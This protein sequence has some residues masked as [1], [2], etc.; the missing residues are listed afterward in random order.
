[1]T[2][3]PGIR[4]DAKDA[5]KTLD[6][7]S[8]QVA[9]QTMSQLRTLSAQGAT[10]FGA[11]NKEELTLLRN[12]I[13]ALEAGGLSHKALDANLQIIRDKMEKVT[14]WSDGGRSQ[15]TGG[16]LSTQEQA[17]LDALRKRFGR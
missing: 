12:S 4:T 1:M 15:P 17:E 9:L 16:G 11:L 6:T 14:R 7:I 8:G 3:I 5:Q 2:N 10:G 13:S